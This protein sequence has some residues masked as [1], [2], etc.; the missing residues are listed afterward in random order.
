M[1]PCLVVLVRNCQEGML[2]IRLS[3]VARWGEKER[4]G[5]QTGLLRWIQSV[6][7][8]G[9]TVLTDWAGVLIVAGFETFIQAFGV[10]EPVL[11]WQRKGDLCQLGCQPTALDQQS[12]IPLILNAALLILKRTTVKLC[13]TSHGHFLKIYTEDFTHLYVIRGEGWFWNHWQEDDSDPVG[14]IHTTLLSDAQ[15]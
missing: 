8:G 9:R 1:S 4:Q 14:G 5:D 7:L 11:R 13:L 10:C 3:S 6:W 12:S 2:K 15:I